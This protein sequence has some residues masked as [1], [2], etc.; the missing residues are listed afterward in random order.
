MQALV[1]LAGAAS[2]CLPTHEQSTQEFRRPRLP[3]LEPRHAR[4][5]SNTAIWLLRC[6]INQSRVA[7]TLL[8]A[9]SPL[10]GMTA[11]MPPMAKQPRLWHVFTTSCGAGIDWRAVA[12]LMSSRA[13]QR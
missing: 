4:S 13:G 3:E 6:L 10:M 12:A 8:A 2:A 7:L 1:A 9:S 11:L 5:H